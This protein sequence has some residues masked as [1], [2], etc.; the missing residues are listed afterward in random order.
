MIKL[1]KFLNYFFFPLLLLGFIILSSLLFFPEFTSV[2]FPK[3]TN[4]KIKI[5]INANNTIENKTQKTAKLH[6][7]NAKTTALNSTNYP[8]ITDHTLAFIKTSGIDPTII[9]QQ[10]ALKTNKNDNNQITTIQLNYGKFK[11]LQ[12]QTTDDVPLKTYRINDVDFYFT[13]YLYTNQIKPLIQQLD[14]WQQ[15]NKRPIQML[16]TFSYTS[17]KAKYPIYLNVQ[18][19]SPTAKDDVNIPLNLNLVFYNKEGTKKIDYQNNQYL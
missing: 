18:I 13:D 9:N 11:L 5:F 1:Q 2:F 17:K 12:N 14:A 19:Y 8:K 16:W 10:I 4:Q 15:T 7:I 3:P 6:K